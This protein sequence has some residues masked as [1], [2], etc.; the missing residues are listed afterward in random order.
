M[1]GVVNAR[2]MASSRRCAASFS[3]NW[4]SS[5]RMKHKPQERELDARQIYHHACHFALVEH[6]ARHK[7]GGIPTEFVAPCT[8]LSAFA[9]ELSFKCIITLENNTFSG[10]H[11]LHKLFG[12]ITQNRRRR[13]IALWDALARPRL[14]NMPQ[15]DGIQL[16]IDL[17]GALEACSNTFEKVRYI[18][19]PGAFA[20]YLRADPRRS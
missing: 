20:Y 4:L 1:G 13:I 17:P 2:R 12:Q 3:L 16:P 14:V 18:Y 5:D 6:Y 9:V 15:M 10:T 19:E 7:T 8:V 11:L